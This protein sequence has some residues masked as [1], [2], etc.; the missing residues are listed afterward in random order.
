MGTQRY[1]DPAGLLERAPELGN[2]ADSV[3]SVAVALERGDPHRVYR[4]LW[5]ARLLGKVGA[6]RPVVDELLRHRRLFVAPAKRTPVLTTINGVGASVYGSA[7]ADA[8]GTYVKTHFLTVVFVPLFPLAQY[9]VADAEEG[10]KKQGWYFIGKLPMS[11]PIWLWNR[12][13]VLGVFGALAGAAYQAVWAARHNDV[14]FVNALPR[15]VTARIADA[16]LSVPAGGRVAV[17]VP[18][19]RHAVSVKA[20]G[21]AEIETGELDVEGGTDVFVWNVAGAA[22]LYRAAVFYVADGGKQPEDKPT[23]YC[24]ERNIRTPRPDY[25]FQVPPSSIKMSKSQKVARRDQLDLD[26]GG[27]RACAGYLMSR[28]R[29]KLKSSLA[30]AR[31]LLLVDDGGLDSLNTGVS[32]MRAAGAADEALVAARTAVGKHQNSIDH[33]RLYQTLAQASG[34]QAELL[35]A[36]RA[37]HAEAPEAAD[38]AYLYARLLPNAEALVMGR[39]WLARH[40]EHVHFGRLVSFGTVRA[41]EFAEALAILE[42]VHDAAR[43]EWVPLAED[44]VLALAALAR[45]EEAKRVAAEAFTL[46]EGQQKLRLAATYG[47][48]EGGGAKAN[49]LFAKL[50]EQ[51]PEDLARW[52]IRFW[53]APRQVDVAK[54]GQGPFADYWQLTHAAHFEPRGALGRIPASRAETLQALDEE[55]LVL[56]LG[57]ARR[58]GDTAALSRLEPLVDDALPGDAIDAYLAQGAWTDAVDELAM[59]VRAALHVARSRQPGLPAAEVRRLRELAA[60]CD[61]V[62]GFASRALESWPAD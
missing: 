41:L 32:L 6:L 28:P 53:T 43:K 23:V 57:E 12:L 46:A 25:L 55:V 62:H 27:A 48:L 54:V 29:P 51:Q 39:E 58:I 2:V 47:W 49:A 15:A 30:L 61:A 14:H 5:W 11:W 45:V 24:G 44:H 16:E 35:E 13:V 10:G 22:P 19:G 18:A 38:A 1:R 59:G 17:S 50:P 31:A 33:H 7:D 40:P 8:D 52:G 42:R 36:Y 56:L 20:A 4:A 26:E 60:R 34:Q 3:P 37:R 9:L 21:G